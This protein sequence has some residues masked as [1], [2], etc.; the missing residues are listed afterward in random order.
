MELTNKRFGALLVSALVLLLAFFSITDGSMWYDEICRVMDP[1][2]GDLGATLQFARECGQ[3]GYMLFMMLWAKL[4]SSGEFILRCSNLP[5]VCIA[6][7][8]AFKI[9]RS[10]GWADGWALVFFVHPMF[11]YY[12]DETT[13][14][15]ILYALSLAFIDHV[16]CVPDFH[17]TR[18]L[19]TLNAIYLLGVFVHFIFGFIILFYF[20]KCLLVTLKD[21]RLVLHH[22]KIMACFCPAY[23]PL[24]AVYAS[25]LN[26]AQTGFGLRSILY[27]PY[28]FLGLQGVGLSRNDLRAKNFDKL[29]PVHVVLIS[30]FVIALVCMFALFLRH[31]KGFYTR[32]RELLLGLAGYFAVILPVAAVV[33]MGLWER[34]CMT[35]FPVY[36]IL[37]IDVYHCLLRSGKRGRLI[38]AVYGGLLCVSLANIALNYAYSCDDYKGVTSRL[39]SLF[40][41]KEDLIVVDNYETRYYSYL[42]AVPDPDAQIVHAGEKTDDE[43]A[44]CFETAEADDTLLVLFEKNS[45]KALYR[46]FDDDPRF[47]VDDRYNSFKLISLA[48]SGIQ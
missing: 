8:Y 35:A 39:A 15:I 40:E 17:S 27:I 32:N 25:S 5:F 47:T 12:M 42:D 22:A 14:Y 28:A 2:L 43:I 1:I 45:S 33:H 13:P 46:R 31:R 41:Q 10:R 34:H 3:P 11:S 7:Y 26:G 23:L 4:T 9:L 19:V 21:K 24:L 29:Q 44:A 18:N 36:M 16:F 48:D 38:L 30:L 20:V 37:A 6:L